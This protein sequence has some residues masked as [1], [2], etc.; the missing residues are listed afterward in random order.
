MPPT[1]TSD[2]K[3]FADPRSSRHTITAYGTDHVAVDGRILKRSLLLLPD[4]LDETWGPDAFAAL[5]HHH[6]ELLVPVACDVL[7]LGTGNRQRFPAPALLRP[8]IEAG[9]PVEIMD[10]PAACRTY[11]ILIA[12]GRAVA[13]ALIVETSI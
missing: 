7:L 12:E 11:N 6:L 3:L 2:L 1:R 13:A 9:R 5:A 4:R 8:L 10:T